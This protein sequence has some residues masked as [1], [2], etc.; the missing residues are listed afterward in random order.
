MTNTGIVRQ[1]DK[2]GRIT[3]PMELRRSL[4]F[5]ERETLSIYTEHDKIIL[6]KYSESEAADIFTGSTTDSIEFEGKMVSRK[7]I[8]KLSKLAGLI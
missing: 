2:L 6:K 4:G 1:L 5:A 7:S 8:E 3:L